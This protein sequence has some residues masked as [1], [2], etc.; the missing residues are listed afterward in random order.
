MQFFRDRNLLVQTLKLL[1]R[2]RSGCSIQV[3]MDGCAP[4]QHLEDPSYHLLTYHLRISAADEVCLGKELSK[5][6]LTLPHLIGVTNT[7]YSKLLPSDVS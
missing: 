2:N 3:P 5:G 7:E 1:D 4:T 6:D